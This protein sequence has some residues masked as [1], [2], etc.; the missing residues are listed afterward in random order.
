MKSMI[1]KICVGLIL[2][3]MAVPVSATFVVGDIMRGLEKTLEGV[4]RTVQSVSE[5]MKNQNLEE[6]IQTWSGTVEVTTKPSWQM[7]DYL[8]KTPFN[9]LP[10]SKIGLAQED[11]AAARE[12][13]RS[14]F[15][16]PAG[17]DP[18]DAE[19]EAI[20]ALRREYVS[21]LA[22]E[23]TT[24]ATGIR[25]NVAQDLK[26]TQEAEGSG[27]GILQEIQLDTQT[28]RSLTMLSAANVIMGI[29][30][31]ELE[32][33]QMLLDKDVVLETAPTGK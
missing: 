27:G 18:T 7:Y 10:S 9:T 17:S 3:G 21:T 5:Q 30:M 25:E 1:E 23:Q 16:L 29:K 32:A 2:T 24:L 31:M 12:F 6:Q 14:T 26:N 8:L 13:V 19:K 33:A 22:Q 11:M 15:F 4:D 20:L 28:M